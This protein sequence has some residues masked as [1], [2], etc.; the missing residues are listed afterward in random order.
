MGSVS[1]WDDSVPYQAMS[2]LLGRRNGF[3]EVCR[4]H[5]WGFATYAASGLAAATGRPGTIPARAGSRR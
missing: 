5:F 1:N 2:A 3:T 4:L